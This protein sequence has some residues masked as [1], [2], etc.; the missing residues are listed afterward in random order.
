MAQG[1]M[2]LSDVLRLQYTNQGIL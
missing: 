2:T 1:K